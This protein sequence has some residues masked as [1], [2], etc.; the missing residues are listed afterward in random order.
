MQESYS[1]HLIAIF[2]TDIPDTR[3]VK[4]SLTCCFKNMKLS[5]VSPQ[6]QDHSCL[7]R[8]YSITQEERDRGMIK[9]SRN[10]QTMSDVCIN[11]ESK[12]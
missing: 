5:E 8:T 4:N 2:L 11:I 7:L 10:I 12:V 9:L 6:N 1:G 3:I